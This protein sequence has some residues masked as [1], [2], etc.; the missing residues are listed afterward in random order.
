MC[1]LD[2]LIKHLD[3]PIE[4]C[5]SLE[6]NKSVLHQCVANFIAELNNYKIYTDIMILEEIVGSFVSLLSSLFVQTP[7]I[8][9]EIHQ[10]EYT[11]IYDV[12]PEEEEVSNG[13]IH[14][15]YESETPQELPYYEDGSLASIHTVVGVGHDFL[16]SLLRSLEANVGFLVAVVFIIASLIVVIVFLDLNTNDACVEWVLTNSSIPRHVRMLKLIGMSVKLVPP[17]SWFPVCIA[18]LWGYEEFRKNYLAC[19]FVSSFVPGVLC[20]T[21]RIIVMNKFTDLNYSY[22]VYR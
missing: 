8:S 2:I 7:P 17:F 12:N 4:L 22:N 18:M 13:L 3:T 9:R 5:G 6:F 1:E 19:L 11:L 16:E 21:Y 20:C 10:R 14:R 15:E